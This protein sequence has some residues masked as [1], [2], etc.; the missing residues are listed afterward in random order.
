MVGVNYGLMIAFERGCDACVA[1]FGGYWLGIFFRDRAW[2]EL[3]EFH[4]V[5]LLFD[6][7]DRVSSFRGLSSFSFLIF[8]LKV[9]SLLLRDGLVPDLGLWTVQAFV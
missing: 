5:K 4:Q 8:I 2:L 7:F 9:H 6:I 1:F 3:V